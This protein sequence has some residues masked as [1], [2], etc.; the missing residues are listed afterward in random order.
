MYNR[1]M[2]NIS[3]KTLAAIIV[4]LSFIAL[5]SGFAFVSAEFVVLYNQAVRPIVYGA[6]LIFVIAF[7]G[8]DERPVL[9]AGD[10]TL[11]A[12]I[13]SMAYL[14]ILFVLGI[15]LALVLM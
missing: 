12:L 7:I 8:K 2:T 11:W 10:S 4:L 3:K 1:I 13:F 14:F 6:L 15:I 5:Q 9:K